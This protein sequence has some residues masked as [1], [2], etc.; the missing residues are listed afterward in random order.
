MVTGAHGYAEAVEQGTHIEVMDV[1]HQERDDTA[2]VLGFAKDAH[3]FNLF[4]ALHGI[5]GEFV[6]VGF[7]LLHADGRNNRGCRLR[8]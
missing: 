8:T 2:L 7:Y 1:P 3:A 6:F 5:L 4:Q